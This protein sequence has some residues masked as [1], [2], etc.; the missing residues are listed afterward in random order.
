MF[1]ATEIGSSDATKAELAIRTLNDVG[2]EDEDKPVLDAARDFLIRYFSGIGNKP[3][4][5]IE[6]LKRLYEANTNVG[7]K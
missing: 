1:T 6:R 2:V 4:H 5:E 7:A 3:D